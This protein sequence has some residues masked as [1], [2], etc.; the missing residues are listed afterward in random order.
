ME[1]FERVG[2][3]EC[4]NGP[5][6]SDYKVHVLGVPDNSTLPQSDRGMADMPVAF[7]TASFEGTPYAFR[8][9]SLR[10]LRDTSPY[11][12]NGRFSTL[13]G[14]LDFYDDLPRNPNVRRDD[15]DPLAQR[16]GEVND[17]ADAIVAFLEAL[18][19]NS[20]DKVIPLR[21]PSGLTPGGR[22]H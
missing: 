18:N 1:R 19:D 14:V 20:F 22:I 21:V 6:F 9:A 17:A 2:C 13:R 15:V 7:R 5:M 12:H 3:I 16:L 4:H 10:N 8:T 11:M